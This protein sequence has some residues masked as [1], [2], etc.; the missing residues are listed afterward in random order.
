MQGSGSFPAIGGVVTHSDKSRGVP[1][2]NIIIPGEKNIW[3]DHEAERQEESL[4]S[5]CNLIVIQPRHAS[6]LLQHG[7]TLSEKTK[8]GS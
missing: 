1:L 3:R 4:E 2:A 8:A 6:F 7:S 5:T